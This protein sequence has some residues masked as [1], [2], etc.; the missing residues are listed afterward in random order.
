MKGRNLS[1]DL[2]G[3]KLPTAVLPFSCDRE[4]EAWNRKRLIRTLQEA[5]EGELTQ[6]QR[7][8]LKRY[9]FD[10]FSQEEIAGVMGVTPATVSRH[11]KKARNRLERVIGYAYPTLQKQ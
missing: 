10:G 8:C 2:F 9:Y 11:L 3:E 6:R 1:L 5:I 4:E 7:E